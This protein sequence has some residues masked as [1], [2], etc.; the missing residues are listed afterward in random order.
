[1]SISFY[2]QHLINVTLVAALKVSRG[3]FTQSIL[4]WFCNFSIYQADVFYA[5]LFKY[6]KRKY[7]I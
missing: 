3:M 5:T 1:M 2:T 6:P 4:I 7:L